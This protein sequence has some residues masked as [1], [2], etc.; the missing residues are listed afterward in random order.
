MVYTNIFIFRTNY[1][2]RPNLNNSRVRK[3]TEQPFD[4]DIDM[5]RGQQLTN[6]NKPSQNGIKWNETQ[7]KPTSTQLFTTKSSFNTVRNHQSINPKTSKTS[8]NGNNTLNDDSPPSPVELY[9]ILSESEVENKIDSS[10][11]F[12]ANL[13]EAKEDKL[14]SDSKRRHTFPK[15]CHDESSEEESTTRRN[16]LPST[17]IDHT[18]MN[19]IQR[20]LHNNVESNSSNKKSFYGNTS[21]YFDKIIRTDNGSKPDEDKK[22]KLSDK[23]LEPNKKKLSRRKVRLAPAFKTGVSCTKHG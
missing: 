9:S 6:P 15:S 14:F 3:H 19:N 8:Q 12:E 22:R 10:E 17:S 11:E 1:S 7:R 23:Q 16:T 2:P 21:S 18:T 13:S 20:A 4:S 5:I